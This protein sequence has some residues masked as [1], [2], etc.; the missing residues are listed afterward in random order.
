MLPGEKKNPK[1]QLKEHLS[2]ER[3]LHLANTVFFCCLLIPPLLSVI[4]SMVCP[5][6]QKTPSFYQLT[7]NI[8]IM[9]FQIFAPKAA[10][11]GKKKV[12]TSQIPASLA[13]DRYSVCLAGFQLIRSYCMI[14]YFAYAT[15]NIEETVFQR[16]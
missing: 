11:F 10:S 1:A 13:L 3:K 15:Y 9:C 12:F 4:Y 16:S 8:Q 14:K 6:R 2:L 5:S 7:D